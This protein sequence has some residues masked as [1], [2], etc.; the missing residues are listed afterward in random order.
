MSILE[1]AS[2]VKGT[3]KASFDRLASGLR[4]PLLQ[5]PGRHALLLAEAGT[6]RITASPA[7]LQPPLALGSR[8]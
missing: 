3:G 4:A 6:D 2:A 8:C 7:W 1:V 5:V